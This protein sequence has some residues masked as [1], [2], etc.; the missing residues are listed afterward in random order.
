MCGSWHLTYFIFMKKENY[1]KSW[2]IE[3][4][5]THFQNTF[6]SAKFKFKPFSV[7][8]DIKSLQETSSNKKGYSYV[9]DIL[10][11]EASVLY[12]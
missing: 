8:N 10:L 9:Q 4:K 3:K 5:S 1:T 7:S 2:G 12:I 6:E 11:T